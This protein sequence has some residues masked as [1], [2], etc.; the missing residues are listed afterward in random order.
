MSA[1]GFL[2]QVCI[3]AYGQTGS[4]KTF[5]MEG[6]PE[7]VCLVCSNVCVLHGGGSAAGLWLAGLLARLCCMVAPA[8][9]A[10]DACCR[11]D[12]SSQ[13]VS[14]AIAIPALA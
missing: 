14:T 3:F 9:R 1:S 6:S 4:G 5:S 8:R 12:L 13:Q 10:L 7:Q 2:L 11:H